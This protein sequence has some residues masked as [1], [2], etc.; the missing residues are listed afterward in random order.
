MD[1]RSQT[2]LSLVLLGL[3]GWA[4]SALFAVLPFLNTLKVEAPG[5]AGG[6]VEIRATNPAAVGASCGFAIGGGLCFL[7]AA[8]AT[9]RGRRRSE[10]EKSATADRARE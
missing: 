8:L 1:S 9:D 6:K 3:M 5:P 4:A 10:N 7:G 2:D